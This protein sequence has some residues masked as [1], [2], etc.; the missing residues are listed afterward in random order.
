VRPGEFHTPPES[1]QREVCNRG[2]AGGRCD[3]FPG[4]DAADAVRFSITTGQAGKLRL[5][6]ILEKEHA[7][8][9]H[10]AVEF[11]AN[12]VVFPDSHGDDLLARQ[13]R[14]FV[15]SYLRKSGA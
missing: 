12:E 8:A 10:G 5:V 3:R 7:P 6:Y 15:E 9:S 14:A 2:Y 11:S 4:G 13:A 1:H